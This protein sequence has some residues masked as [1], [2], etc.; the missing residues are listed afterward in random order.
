MQV[1]SEPD[2]DFDPVFKAGTAAAR[3]LLSAE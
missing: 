3:H 1:L 2:K